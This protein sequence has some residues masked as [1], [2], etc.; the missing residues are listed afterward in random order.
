MRCEAC[1]DLIYALTH[2]D[3]VVVVASPEEDSP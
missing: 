1:D 2:M 3:P